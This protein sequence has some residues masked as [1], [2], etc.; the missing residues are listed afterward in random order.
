[1]GF[2]PKEMAQE[3]GKDLCYTIPEPIGSCVWKNFLSTA[4][5]MSEC[6]LFTNNCQ[7]TI[8]ETAKNCTPCTP[9]SPNAPTNCAVVDGKKICAATGI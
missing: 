6:N 8:N 3:T 4:G 1:M 5:P 9:K 2:D 7:T